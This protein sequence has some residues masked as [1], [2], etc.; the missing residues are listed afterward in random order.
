MKGKIKI[1]AK[2]LK[3]YALITILVVLVVGLSILV[4][5]SFGDGNILSNNTTL[6]EI[7]YSGEYRLY[8]EKQ[9]IAKSNKEKEYEEIIE[10]RIA[11]EVEKTE[12]TQANKLASI[13]ENYNTSVKK[14]DDDLANKIAEYT[15]ANEEAIEKVKNDETMNDAN[16]NIKITELNKKLQELVDSETKDANAEKKSLLEKYNQS[17]VNHEAETKDLIESIDEEYVVGLIVAELMEKPESTP[18]NPQYYTLTEII[19]RVE[20]TP[21]GYVYS[22]NEAENSA[23]KAEFDLEKTEDANTVGS[24]REDAL[25][26]LT[27]TLPNDNTE[28]IYSSKSGSVVYNVTVPV[29]GFYNIL[30]DYIP[31]SSTEAMGASNEGID[32]VS[33]G[34]TI[35]RTFYVDGKLPYDDLSNVSFLRSWADG[36]EKFIDATGNEIKPKQVEKPQRLQQYVKDAI[37]YVTEPYLVYFTAGEHTIEIKSVKENIGIANVYLTTKEKYDSYKDYYEQYKNEKVIEGGIAYKLQGEGGEYQYYEDNKVK[38]IL[39]T[40]V[41]RSSSTIYGI[42]DRTSAYNSTIQDGK[43]IDA[44]PVKIVLNAIGGTKWSSPGDWIKWTVDV[45]ESGLYQISLRSKQNVSRGLFSSRKLAIDGAVPFAEA[46]NCKFVYGSEWSIVTL[47]GENNEEYYFY[48]EAGQHTISLECTLGDYASEIAKIQAIIDDLNAV[49]RKIIQKTGIS[50]DPYMDYFKNEA[51]KKLI[52][53]IKATFAECVDIINEVSANIT[54]ISGEKSSETASLETM[55]IQLEQFIEDETKIQKNLSDFSTNISSLGTWILNVSQQA[56]TIDYI[57]LHS[58]DYELPK[59]NPNFFGSLWFGIRGFFGSFFFD[60]ESV[61]LGK[62]N[63]G[64]ETIDVWLCTS[65]SQGREQANAISAMISEACEDETSKLY[66]LNVKLKV[67]SSDVLLTA[68]LA[69]RGPDVA[70]NIGNGTPVNYALRGAA[71]NLNLAPE[72]KFTVKGSDEVVSFTREAINKHFEGT[73]VDGS[74]IS[75]FKEIALAEELELNGGTR[76]FQNSAMTPYRFNSGAFIEDGYYAL[77]YTQSYLMMF[78]RTDMFEEYGWDVPKTW[79]DVIQLI[80]ELQ[81][82]NFQFYLP[83]NT[84]GASSVVNQI[85]ASYL[86]QNVDDIYQAFYRTKIREGK[87][88]TPQQYIESNFDSVEAQEAFEFWCSFYTEYSFPLAASFVNRFRSGE[89]PVG[90]VGYDIYNTLAVSAPEI[91]GKWKFAVMPGTMEMDDQ[92]NMVVDH[93]GAA[94]GMS[95]MM[96]GTTKKPYEAWAFMDWFTDADTQ[97]NYAREI[98]AILGA[99]ARHNTANVAAFTRLAW[100]EEEKEI[101]M[102]QWN[103]TVG[104][105]EVAGGYY[106][107]RNL[108]NAFREVVNNNFNPRQILSDYIITINSEIDR[109]REEFGLASSKKDAD[110]TK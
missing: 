78:Y 51:G 25:A 103:N 14:V 76:R 88:G 80:P 79:N 57:M 105:P 48:L 98:E 67:V 8:L 74:K 59:A 87:D 93:Q 71:F 108:E 44:S 69:G 28:Y 40:D 50:P 83:L 33:G 35:E 38:S 72:D 85:F 73:D 58:E 3:K 31:Y 56:L 6:N 66:G 26:G 10:E 13:H 24:V 11:K 16:K 70:I 15:A 77:P 27:F 84:S 4:I 65:E 106:T 52:A 17:L 92:G 96:M 100:T 9:L 29:D 89:T 97:V 36:G 32:E 104:V 42:S 95:L 55:A 110:P 81:I 90:I 37:G 109:K 12:N 47:G 46:M 107:G 53:E 91:K 54:K 101:L 62:E 22:S 86:Y 60:Y 82:M 61:G 19:K 18:E 43:E 68:T 64:W 2:M 41:T 20:N 21:N 30:L 45:K 23:I 49:Y 63:A 102:E 5:R 99:A 39:N 94:S 7:D 1:T 75:T 34:A